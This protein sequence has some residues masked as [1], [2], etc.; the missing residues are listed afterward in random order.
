MLDAHNPRMPERFQ[1]G[2]L[3]MLGRLQDALLASQTASSMQQSFWPKV[4]GAAQLAARSAGLL[5]IAMSAAFSSV[6]GLLG[7]AGQGNYAAANTV[8]DAWTGIQ[9][10][11][12]HSLPYRPFNLS[13]NLFCQHENL[14]QHHIQDFDIL[15]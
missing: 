2:S 13:P 8:L 10:S 3:S 4:A 1:L 11:Q 7:S 12:V 9:A 5:P 14:H 15:S 6:A